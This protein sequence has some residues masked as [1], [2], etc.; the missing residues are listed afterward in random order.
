MANL[1]T[2]RGDHLRLAGSGSLQV[3]AAPSLS[4]ATLDHLPSAVRRP[5]FDVDALRPGILHLGCGAFH[6]THQAVFTQRAIEAEGGAVPPPWGIAATSL[7]RPAMRDAL[8][9]QDG[10]YTVLERGPD[11]LRAEVVGTLREVGF[12]PAEMPELLSRFADPAIRVVTL[13]VT[14]SAYCLDPLTNRLCPDHPEIQR[15]LHAA[16]PR[17]AMGVLVGGLAAARAAGGPPPVVLSCDNLPGNG[18]ALRQAAID[19]AALSDDRLASWIG[20]A[21]QFPNSMVDRITP[22]TTELDRADA[23]AILGLTDAAPVA[24][25]PFRQWV[26]E[27]FD[28][29]R[30]RWDAAG[31]EFVPDVAPWEASKLRLLNGTHMAIAYLGALAG[32]HTV[33]EVVAEPVFAEYALRFML[34]EQKPTLPPSRHDI[35]AYARQ[36]LQRWRNPGIAHEL[37]RVGRNGSDKLQP[38]LLASLQEN[39]QAGRPAPCTLLAIAA[40]VRCATRQPGPQNAVEMQDPLTARLRAVGRAAGDDAA[41]LI[42]AVLDMEDVF[43]SELPRRE[44][45]RAA[46]TAAVAALRRDGPQ[47]TVAALLA[48]AP[49]AVVLEAA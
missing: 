7:Q 17:G 3:T 9:P 19:F 4:L 28:G 29:P 6:R 37:G 20:H 31:A 13:T 36:L 43:G 16:T 11:G 12:A 49:A 1:S 45:F 23:A 22:A 18:H 32:L 30:P 41:R 39:L 44:S 46:L 26:I 24:A 42:G 8:R 27:D 21:V 33:A 48:D 38:R 40:W 47:A 2:L 25:E 34:R 15:D 5:G 14:S 10:L 35:D